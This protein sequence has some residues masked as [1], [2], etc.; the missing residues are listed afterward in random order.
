MKNC[1]RWHS[2]ATNLP[3]T[4]VSIY[5]EGCE[6]I[7]STCWPR[8]RQTWKAARCQSLKYLFVVGG[9]NFYTSEKDLFLVGI[10][11]M[12]IAQEICKSS[13]PSFCM[14][15]IPTLDVSA[16]INDK[17]C[18]RLTYIGNNRLTTYLRTSGFVQRQRHQRN[19]RDKRDPRQLHS[20]NKSWQKKREMIMQK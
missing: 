5:D 16:W 14:L 7:V 15:T 13:L 9:N 10:N 3:E 1:F 4:F 19:Q 6:G 2:W 12:E 20:Q 8:N 18:P 17:Q 11:G